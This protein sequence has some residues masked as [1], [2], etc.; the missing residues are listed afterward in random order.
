MPV[1]EVAW[2]YVLVEVWDW[3][4]HVALVCLN[5]CSVLR[6]GAPGGVLTDEQHELVSACCGCQGKS[7]PS[8]CHYQALG[9]RGECVTLLGCSTNCYAGEQQFCELGTGSFSLGCLRA[10]LLAQCILGNAPCM[11]QGWLGECREHSSKGKRGEAFIWL[12]DILWQ[13]VDGRWD[14]RN[15]SVLF[16]CIA[17]M[18]KVMQWQC[19]C[20]EMF[21]FGELSAFFLKYFFLKQFNF[22]WR[23]S[24]SVFSEM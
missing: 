11:Q 10:V 1:N 3:P 8:C 19:S 23:L 2:L 24:W 9:M 21:F 17:D 13:A 18:Q 4:A 20:T 12:G 5:S 22:L 14:W 15:T 16:T 7:C 6:L